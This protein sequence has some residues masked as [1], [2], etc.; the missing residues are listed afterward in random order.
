MHVDHTAKTA[1]GLRTSTHFR[2]IAYKIRPRFTFPKSTFPEHETG[3]FYHRRRIPYPSP[4]STSHSPCPP[5]GTSLGCCPPP[6]WLPGPL[7]FEKHFPFVPQY[8]FGYPLQSRDVEHSCGG[9]FP[10]PGARVRNPPPR[11]SDDV[12]HRASECPVRSERC[13]RCSYRLD[14]RSVATRRVSRESAQLGR[15]CAFSTPAPGKTKNVTTRIVTERK[16]AFQ[17]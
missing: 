6:F 8:S 17:V 5:I 4:S 15:L 1:H 11:R 3:R 9:P 14:E 16:R 12:P 10:P 7:P 13:P 2:L